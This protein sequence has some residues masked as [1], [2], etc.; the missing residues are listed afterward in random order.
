[1]YIG[2]MFHW[3]CPE[4][5]REI[6]PSVKHCSACEP[7]LCGPSPVP[8]PRSAVPVAPAAAEPV[9]GTA[10]AVALLTP[11][12]PPR[13]PADLLASPSPVQLPLGLVTGRYET[14]RFELEQ[15]AAHPK[16]VLALLPCPEPAPLPLLSSLQAPATGDTGMLP[17]PLPT[18]GGTDALA[19]PLVALAAG[20]ETEKE[21]A[22][23]PLPPASGLE[24]A[25]ERV[26][27]EPIGPELIGPE[28]IGPEPIGP[29]VIAAEPMAPVPEPAPEPEPAM[30]GLTHPATGIAPPQPV[31]AMPMTR[32]LSFP[33]VIPAGTAPLE[34]MVP[35]AVPLADLAPAAVTTRAP[36]ADALTPRPAAPGLI[37][38]GVGALPEEALAPGEGSR[39]SNGLVDAMLALGWLQDYT[40][41]ASRN[42]RPAPPAPRIMQSDASA[43]ITLPGPA[44]PAELLSLS[45]AGISAIPGYP[46]RSTSTA[47][48]GWVVS[49]AVMVLL[50]L[51]GVG[52]LSYFVPNLMSNSAA[53]AGPG[54]G[55]GD[56]RSSDSRTGDAPTEVRP[57][58]YPLAKF[59][60]VTGFRFVVDLN[61]RSEV[62]YLVV[63]HSGATLNG[64]NVFVTL[65]TSGSK[66]G[67]P[68]L[69]RFSFRAPDM[70]PFESK[71]MTSSIDKL[72]RS[73]AVP[74]WQDLRADV[75]IGQ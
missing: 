19:N 24:I 46:R 62:H 58:A 40:A 18:A 43:R 6:P 38:P 30:A 57:S 33:A 26:I 56:V 72:T 15:D 52:L 64:V 21:I 70:E 61:R 16:G 4:C 12:D 53:S 47:F 55:P 8:E 50:L 20:V 32:A 75:E 74:D 3:I 13:A 10:V 48:P 28:L 65:R 41:A 27:P 17:P 45:Q 51:G 63:N 60:E 66:P 5:G 71:E 7:A 34:G 39:P 29:D 2:S 37:V 59:V 49:L 31:A 44:L 23:P 54:E 25:A 68:P 42:M 67:Q 9:G 14:G 36:D 35:C 73:V 11:V 69:C 22:P 1:V